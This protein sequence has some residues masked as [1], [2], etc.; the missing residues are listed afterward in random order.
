MVP[1]LRSR[2]ASFRSRHS[3]LLL[4]NH[5]HADLRIRFS[6]AR[7]MN[8]NAELS[9]PEM[10]E[11]LKLTGERNKGPTIRRLIEEALQQP[12]AGSDRPALPQRRMGHGAGNP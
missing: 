11:I 2:F 5:C 7:I 12:E 1:A 9:D 6:R 3:S 4:R 8:V 10:A